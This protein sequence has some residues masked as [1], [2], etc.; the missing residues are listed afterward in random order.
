M[1]SKQKLLYV[2]DEVINRHIIMSV[3]GTAYDVITAESGQDGLQ[4]LEN[5][6]EISVVISDFRM[7]GMD[8]LEFIR[9]ARIDYLDKKYFILSGH[10]ISEEIQ[11]ALEEKVISE[12]FQKPAN[13][14]SIDKAIKEA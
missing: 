2:D 6:T 12:Y 8:G 7:P 5:D 13:F 14:A 9:K 10:A 11:Q 3:L 1:D 4:K